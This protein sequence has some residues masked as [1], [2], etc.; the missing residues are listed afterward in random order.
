MTESSLNNFEMK[1]YWGMVLRRRYLVISVAFAVMFVFTLGGYIW[2]ET[3]EA[4]STVFIQRG[5]IMDPLI[6]GVGTSVSMEGRLKSLKNSLTSRNIID[7]VIKK[8]DLETEARS[9]QAYEGL[10]DRYQKKIDV[11][12]KIA[13]GSRAAAD[14]FVIS[15]QGSNPKSVRDV[16]NTL[17]DNFV[18]NSDIA[19]TFLY[20]D[21]FKF[22]ADYFDNRAA[23]VEQVT[24][25]DM[26]QAV[27]NI[28][29]S[30]KIITVRA[31]RV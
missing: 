30:D 26:K 13:K 29:A 8:L 20:V 11:D 16:V 23:Q 18:S 22:P 25:D 7:R 28:L 24:L 10:I 2:P 27:K 15:Y 4:S 5:T 6:Q 12:V 17:V 3:Y 14:M 1:R 31:G 9:P 19:S 21:R